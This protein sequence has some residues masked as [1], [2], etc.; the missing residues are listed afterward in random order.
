M[1]DPA[2]FFDNV[3]PNLRVAE[4]AFS[5]YF[6]YIFVLR[7]FASNYPIYNRMNECILTF[8]SFG[9]R[10]EMF[11]SCPKVQNFALFDNKNELQLMHMLRE[12]NTIL[13]KHHEIKS[14]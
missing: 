4:R 12:L 6:L 8:R 14:I 2:T 1:W 3:F 11:D 7:H 9:R 10:G 13:V 5:I